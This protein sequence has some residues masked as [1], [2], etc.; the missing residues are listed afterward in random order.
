MAASHGHQTVTLVC[1]LGMLHGALVQSEIA[2]GKIQNID[3]SEALRVPGVIDYACVDDIPPNGTN[4][5]GLD[6]KFVYDDTEIFAR[7]KVI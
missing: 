7:D 4:Q 3:W 1:F 6:G 2:H 5:P